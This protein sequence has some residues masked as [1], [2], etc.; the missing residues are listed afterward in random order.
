MTICHAKTEVFLEQ[1]TQMREGRND[2]DKLAAV[3][4]KASRPAVRF[5][6][7]LGL[8][9]QEVCIADNDDYESSSDESLSSVL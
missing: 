1:A 7:I 6:R 4:A 5:A 8:A 3:Y 9:D 2:P